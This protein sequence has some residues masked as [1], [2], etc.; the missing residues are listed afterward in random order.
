MVDSY[1]FLVVA[2]CKIYNTVWL[3]VR[4]CMR[5]CV[6]ACMHVCVCVRVIPV[7]IVRGINPEIWCMVSEQN[8][9]FILYYGKN[10]L[11]MLLSWKLTCWNILIM[12]H[13][14]G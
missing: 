13:E 4:A 1:C 3:C 6:R 2:S 11:Y 14:R 8:M 9:I 5:A 10:H 12:R 7:R